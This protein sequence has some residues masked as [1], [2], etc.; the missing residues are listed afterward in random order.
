MLALL[1]VATPAPSL[2]S[3]G[4]PFGP[5][6][7]DVPAP[8]SARG[9]VPSVCG[10][11]PPLALDGT[12]P[13]SGRW[14]SPVGATFDRTE[15][16]EHDV[17]RIMDDL[18]DGD[19]SLGPIQ[20]AWGLGTAGIG[21]ASILACRLGGQ[22]GILAGLVLG[23]V[24]G[25]ALG[26]CTARRHGRERT[27]FG[28]AFVGAY[29]G[30]FTAGAAA[31]G[32]ASVAGL[33]GVGH[34]ALCVLGGTMVATAA[35]RFCPAS[36]EPETALH[37]MDQ[38][39]DQATE[40]E[41]IFLRSLRN[42]RRGEGGPNGGVQVGEREVV[43]NGLKLTRKASGG[44]G[45]MAPAD[46][47]R[48]EVGATVSGPRPPGHDAASAEISGRDVGE[49][50]GDPLSNVEPMLGA[51]PSVGADLTARAERMANQA[52]LDPVVDLPVLPGGWID[53]LQAEEAS[54]ASF[55]DKAARIK[56]SGI[57]L[58]AGAANA[59]IGRMAASLF[60]LGPAL[61]V[62]AALSLGVAALSVLGTD[63]VM[64]GIDD[65][66]MYVGV[67]F[68]LFAAGFMQIGIVREA[69]NPLVG[70]LGS[71]F[72]AGLPAV[73]PCKMQTVLDHLPERLPQAATLAQKY[74]TYRA[75]HDALTASV[76]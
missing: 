71:A 51:E 44:A 75:Q 60:P 29:L 36:K 40:R 42:M 63:R 8:S 2:S 31:C 25:A 76:A 10:G 64:R 55:D 39:L 61:C 45:N 3:S 21:A 49:A 66:S 50:A 6:G 26:F 28:Y 62:T 30:G 4:R 9:A 46:V 24:G 65:S 48:R 57:L 41:G 59:V 27:A 35:G 20:R 13:S 19:R 17:Q 67:A 74:A 5:S 73:F 72:M 58:A 56:A 23:V 54:I 14:I 11:V 22:G 68:L 34:A 15:I 16:A 69:G 38:A 70:Y 47:S 32:I 37:A 1:G 53:R 43:I 12:A 7:P 52:P 33:P 18:L